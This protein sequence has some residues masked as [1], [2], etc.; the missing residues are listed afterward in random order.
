MSIAY[1]LKVKWFG[2]EKTYI[3]NAKFGKIATMQI[4]HE[5]MV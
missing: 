1:I 2:I 3:N 5:E 4:F